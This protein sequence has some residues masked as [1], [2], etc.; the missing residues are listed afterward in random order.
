MNFNGI[1]ISLSS[2]WIVDKNGS[3]AIVLKNSKIDNSR[4]E[5]SYSSSENAE[6]LAK[7]TAAWSNPPAQVST[8]NI[9]NKSFYYY[10]Q[11]KD[12][13]VLCVDGKDN[14]SYRIAC[15][16]LS[17]DDVSGLISNIAF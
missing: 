5:I 4:L 6:K 16:N 7:S 14:F 15:S 10:E 2:G 11:G 3:S 9:G 1:G 17:L 8:K 13:F 12:M